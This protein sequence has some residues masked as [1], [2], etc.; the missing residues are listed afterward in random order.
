[1][2]F[3][4]NERIVVFRLKRHKQNG[5]YQLQNI[6]KE[7]SLPCF[8]G[9]AFEGAQEGVARIDG[10]AAH[11][12]AVVHLLSRSSHLLEEDAA[13]NGIEQND[14]LALF[15]GFKGVLGAETETYNFQILRILTEQH[16]RKAAAGDDTRCRNTERQRARAKSLLVK[17]HF[18]KAVDTRDQSA[19]VGLAVCG[20]SK[21]IAL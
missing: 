18:I 5:S 16:L 6:H 11:L 17:I 9:S 13:R 10:V 21:G 14:S 7:A 1:M 20:D 4:L 15:V 3:Y 19:I 2:L 8:T 12:I